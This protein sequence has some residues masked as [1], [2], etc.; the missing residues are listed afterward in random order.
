LLPAAQG[1]TVV[2]VPGFLNERMLSAPAGQKFLADFKTATGHDA[3]PGGGAA[4]FGYD[5]MQ[6][7]LDVLRRAGG[8]AGN[9]TAV[10]REFH[11]TKSRASVLGTYNIDAGGDTSLAPTYVLNRIKAG[12]FV[13]FASQQG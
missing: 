11:N 12:K 8:T 5:A 10:V 4:I 2:A 7:V 6:L 3:G 13:P 1:N 9:H